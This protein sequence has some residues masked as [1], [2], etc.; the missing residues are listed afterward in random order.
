MAVVTDLGSRVM[1]PACS[2]PN[3]SAMSRMLHMPAS[4]P[5]RMP[6]KIAR[7]LDFSSES[8][9]YSGIARHTVAGVSSQLRYFAPAA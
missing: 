4:T 5:D 8:F 9:S 7:Q 3:S 1:Y 2:R 6:A